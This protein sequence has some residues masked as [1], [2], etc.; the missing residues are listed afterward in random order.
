MAT[1]CVKGSTEYETVNE[2]VKAE[3]EAAIVLTSSVTED[4]VIPQRRYATIDLAGFT[5]TSA[6]THTITVEDGAFLTVMS[7]NSEGTVDCTVNGK[8]A[9]YVMPG[10]TATLE[11]GK[12]TRSLEDSKSSSNSWYV[13]QNQGY[14]SITGDANIVNTSTLSSAIENGFDSGRQADMDALATK[15]SGYSAMFSMSGGTVTSNVIAVKFDEHSSGSISDGT[16]VAKTQAVLNWTTCTILGGDLSST[17]SGTVVTNGTYNGSAGVL[18]I[19]GGTFT[20]ASPDGNIVQPVEGY[21]SQD[22]TIYGGTYSKAPAAGYLA[23]GVE[24]VTGSDGKVV[25]S[26][27]VWVYPDKGVVGGGFNGFRRLIMSSDSVDYVAG[28]FSIP[29]GFTPTAVISAEAKGGV[30]AWYDAQNRKV[31]LYTARDTE[32][33]G[34]VENLTI[35]M[36]GH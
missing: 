26:S 3:G 6:S 20:A 5:I 7:S 15:G 13:I 33:T 1:V 35:V 21:A 34:T 2:A 24:F 9:L 31:L 18:S 29:E 16:I 28:G 22:I 12:F 10:G 25:A 11:G 8:S 27:A 14:L 23:P 36:I 17:G 19:R 30:M 4:V 32:I